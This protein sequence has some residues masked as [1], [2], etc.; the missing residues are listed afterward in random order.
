MGF[1]SDLDLDV[2]RTAVSMTSIAKMR[3][4]II[5]P[6]ARYIW[7]ESWLLPLRYTV[8]KKNAV[9]KIV[10]PTIFR[11][12]TLATLNGFILT[13]MYSSTTFEMKISTN[14]IRTLSEL[15]S[16]TAKIHFLMNGTTSYRAASSSL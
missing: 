3:Y 1:F 6:M 5:Q 9:V 12:L 8:S 15:T 10:S 7:I 2:K 4:V 16:A 13:S 11:V 14:C